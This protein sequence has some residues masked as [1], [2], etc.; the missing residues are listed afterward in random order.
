MYCTVIHYMYC[1]QNFVS[2]VISGTGKEC[3]LDSLKN[4]RMSIEEHN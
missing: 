1:T 2:T 4:N 3:P